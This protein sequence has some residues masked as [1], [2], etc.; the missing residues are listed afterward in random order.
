M[1]ED[2]DKKLLTDEERAQIQQYMQDLEMQNAEHMN[3]SP[4]SMEQAFK[5]Q[6]GEHFSNELLEC[7]LEITSSVEAQANADKELKIRMYG[8]V[9]PY[10]S[11]RYVSTDR[12]SNLLEGVDNNRNLRISLKSP[13]GSAF[14]GIALYSF[15]RRW[16][17][18]VAV[19]ADGVVASA[20]ALMFLGA[21]DRLVTEDAGSVLMYHRASV[22][23]FAYANAPRIRRMTGRLLQALDMIDNTITKTLVTRAGM[24]VKKVAQFLDDEK[25]LDGPTSKSMGIA[26]GY[27]QTSKGRKGRRKKKNAAQNQAET[28]AF[29]AALH[30]SLYA[31][32]VEEFRQLQ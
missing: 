14:E 15:L 3:E 22:F 21:D 28:D 26:T 7:T 8:P 12:L 6:L 11:P 19:E 5:K 23:L 24:N 2:Q 13:G 25:F 4:A 32:C 10:N 16:G 30:H 1:P 27:M 20:A 18:N 17:G 9:A 31:E 29:L